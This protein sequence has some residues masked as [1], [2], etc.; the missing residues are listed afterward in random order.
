MLLRV[1]LGLEPAGREL[2]TDPQLPE[3]I[4]SLELRGIRWRG[5]RV[6]VLAGVASETA[7][8]DR[9]LGADAFRA[10]PAQSARQLFATL[11]RRVDTAQL[12]GMHSS[13]R[14]DVAGA[15]SWRIVVV[16]GSLHVNESRDPADAVIKVPEDVL[17]QL[18]RGEQNMTTALLSG[19][20]E[21][22]GDF[23]AG[24]QLARVLFRVS[25]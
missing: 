18:V 4:S 19:R 14:F 10:E 8:A 25:A 13:C 16:D 22:L 3:R 5:R 17:L 11:D 1:L 2:R 6:D 24:E 9:A 15:G 12:A 7:A 23:A 20:V 21:F